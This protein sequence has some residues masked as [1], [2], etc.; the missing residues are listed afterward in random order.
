M[1][2]IMS[3][4]YELLSGLYRFLKIKNDRYG[5]SATEPLRIFCTC[6]PEE[7]ICVRID[8]KLSRIKNADTLRKND[9]IDLIGYLVLYAAAMGWT[10]FD[11]LID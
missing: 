1:N 6:G 2:N 5:N 10:D 3:N 11:D 4:V 7:S 8:D 9:V